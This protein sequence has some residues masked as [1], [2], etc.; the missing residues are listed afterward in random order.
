MKFYILTSRDFFALENLVKTIPKED[1]VVIINSLDLSY[2]GHVKLYCEQ[3]D[4]EYVVTES[5][6][7]A[8]TGKNSV[9]RCFLESDNEHMV[10][11]D[12]DDTLTEYGYQFYTNLSKCDNPPDMVVLK[13]QWCYLAVGWRK[14]LDGSLKVISRSRTKPW[15]R[16]KGTQYEFCEPTNVFKTWRKQKKWNNV[17]DEQLM[18]W[19]VGRS[20][21]EKWHWSIAEG[22]E[23]V[24]DVFSRMVFYS[25]KAAQHVN[26]TNELAVGEDMVAFYEMKRLQKVGELNVYC[27][28][29]EEDITYI[30]TNDP[31]NAGVVHDH[32]GRQLSWE[33]PT[34]LMN[35]VND[36]NMKE[37]YECIVNYSLPEITED[38]YETDS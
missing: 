14:R 33:W 8:G 11:I 26:F 37:K 31:K 17:S 6:G 25:R 4:I 5:D 38:Y 27:H 24:K 20:E 22:N 16:T 30:Y 18:R 28:D 35:Y 32:L 15:I 7:T 12:G 9:M 19:A 36:N 21:M 3:N 13:N 23:N 2:V 10:Q 1:I 29:E 34:T